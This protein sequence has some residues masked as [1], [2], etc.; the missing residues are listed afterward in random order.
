[1]E[2]E[3]EKLNPHREHIYYFDFLR[4]FG[5]LCVVFMHTAAAPLRSTVGTAGWQLTN[6]CTSL[7]FTAVPLFL[8]IA[9][10]LS[11]T[12]TKTGDYGYLLKKRIPRLLCTL[13]VWTAIAALWLGRRK[14]MEDFIL[15]LL[16]ALHTP[17]MV[18]FWYM[19]TL[20]ALTLVSPFLYYGLNHLN[21]TGRNVVAVCVALVLVQSTVTGIK[22]T[23][24]QLDILVQLRLFGGSLS[25]YL[26]GWFLG[27]MKTR[28]PNAAL[29]AVFCA[30]LAF[31]AFATARCSAAAGRYN[32]VFQSQS[33]GLTVLLAICIFLLF[34]QNCN[35]D[36]RLRRGL[37]PAA[38]LSLGVYLSHNI[39]LSVLADI[40]YNGTRFLFTCA[41]TVAVF[42]A[43]ALITKTFA[44]IRPLCY[45]FTGM[46]YDEACRT[47]NWQHTAS[48][49]R[50][51]KKTAAV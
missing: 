13:A 12:D 16:S 19:Y 48:R 22:G 15:L 18:H 46:K 29:A 25:A 17:V 30:D 49:L 31:I 43:A 39:L 38:A 33:G 21:R 1:M 4:V 10:Y 44:S 45:V 37:A 32:A 11:L 47:C 5:V 27:K 7:A 35:A 28:I 20:I 41:R 6:V 34:K 8:M 42:V 24:W 9:G 23:D 3:A 40:G 14:G 51:R 36:T 26:L 2:N 50:R